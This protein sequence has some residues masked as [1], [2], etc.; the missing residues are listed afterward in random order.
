MH[1]FCAL[2]DKWERRLK[3]RQGRQRKCSSTICKMWNSHKRQLAPDVVNV[4]RRELFY[5]ES[6]GLREG[7][8]SYIIQ[9]MELDNLQQRLLYNI[10][11]ETDLRSKKRENYLLKSKQ[12]GKSGNETP[13]IQ[14]KGITWKNYL[15]YIQNSTFFKSYSSFYVDLFI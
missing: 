15:L 5:N 7:R 2:S 14:R 11:K 10:V 3:R 1:L 12:V 13:A 8:D 4:S 6:R 9:L